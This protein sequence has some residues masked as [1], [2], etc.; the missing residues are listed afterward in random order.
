MR[1]I[2]GQMELTMKLKQSLSMSQIQFLQILS[3]TNQEL[4]RYLAEQSLENPLLERAEP[5]TVSCGAADWTGPEDAGIF[6]DLSGSDDPAGSAGFGSS[7]RMGGAGVGA[8]GKRGGGKSAESDSM[9]FLLNIAQPEAVSLRRLFSD[10]LRQSDFSREEWRIALFCIDHL[11]DRGYFLL[12]AEE[13]AEETGTERRKV[14][15]VLKK[16]RSLEPCGCFASGLS[17]CLLLQMERKGIKDEKLISIVRDHTD[18]LLKQRILT[19]SK[20]LGVS[21][22]RVKK[23]IACIGTLNPRPLSSLQGGTPAVVIP[24]I[25]CRREGE[26]WHVGLNSTFFGRYGLSD[27]YCVLLRDTGGSEV[28]EY[29]RDRLAHA[30]MILS[31]IERR[32]NLLVRLTELLLK[33][34]SEFFLGRGELRPV[35]MAEAAEKLGVSPSTVTRA[36]REK[37]LQWPGGTIPLKKLF[38]QE[39]AEGSV[40]AFQIKELLGGLIGMEDPRAPY[41][42]NQLA[43]MLKKRGI[44]VSRRT[45]TKY[46]TEMGILTCRQRK[47]YA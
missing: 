43:E 14:K 19:I 42:D 25:V 5:E 30:R 9:S 17:D 36:A 3:M 23:Y 33:S 2:H 21:P 40:S 37:W 26:E 6:I 18:D 28:R 1:E 16:L 13:V 11:D 20:R 45:V 35:T 41:N 31:G 7:V 38:V 15:A 44:A 12:S 39:A 8:T 47:S 27:F 34:Q 4:D 29:F 32:K 46:R 24:D 10:Q 22:E